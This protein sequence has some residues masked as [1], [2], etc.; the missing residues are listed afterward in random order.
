MAITAEQFMD[1]LKSELPKTEKYIDN[2]T[3]DIY[4]NVSEFVEKSVDS[5]S[6]DVDGLYFDDDV[7]EGVSKT[8]KNQKNL[9]K[10]QKIE[11]QHLFTMPKLTNELEDVS[12]RLKIREKKI[13]DIS[14][15]L[16]GEVVKKKM[17]AGLK[18]LASWTAGLTTSFL[19]VSM[20]PI[21]EVI[22]YS[23]NLST[24]LISTLYFYGLGVLNVFGGIAWGV[25]SAGVK[26]LGFIVKYGIVTPVKWFWNIGTAA[27]SYVWKGVKAI[28]GVGWWVI[29][30]AVEIFAGGA[31]TFGK[32]LTKLFINTISNPLNWIAL[33]FILFG[34]VGLFS[35][36]LDK[37]VPVL[38]NFTDS[39][40]KKAYE[41]WPI[42]KM[43]KDYIWKGVENVFSWVDRNI[44]EK[45][46]NWE[47]IST[48][49][50]YLNEGMS[51]LFGK[52]KVEKTKNIIKS[53]LSWI[54]EKGT[55]FISSVKSIMSSVAGFVSK[56]A[57]KGVRK[58]LYDEMKTSQLFYNILNAIPTMPEWAAAAGGEMIR[59]KL[60][61]ILFQMGR[62]SD[63]SK[64][65][66]EYETEHRLK[67]GSELVGIRASSLD[68]SKK[69]AVEIETQISE[70]FG[71][72]LRSMFPGISEGDIRVSIL[73][74]ITKGKEIQ[75]GT[76]TPLTQHQLEMYK[77]YLITIQKQKYAIENKIVD[78]DN[79]RLSNLEN[80]LKINEE[81]FQ[82]RLY[83]KGSS[84]I[85][86]S[87]VDLDKYMSKFKRES[88]NIDILVENLP[89]VKLKWSESLFDSAGRILGPSISFLYGPDKAS[90][91]GFEEEAKWKQL[92]NS[93]QPSKFADGGVVSQNIVQRLNDDTVKFVRDNLKNVDIDLDAIKKK[94]E[95]KRLKQS[96]INVSPTIGSTESYE[97][98][99][100]KQLS[101]SILTI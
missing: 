67:L 3:K 47:I 11:Y 26:T 42:I 53:T 41:T 23:F 61:D 49:S 4:E 95:Q 75:E 54:D 30:S 89:D 79:A 14:K 85:K 66:S 51:K 62:P 71:T 17:V 45:I 77:E 59:A 64:Q 83:I 52:E 24:K 5:F 46:K 29:K 84:D 35:L 65:L 28:F 20:S 72:T 73:T 38:V 74:G 70:E 80:E 48:I 33:P 40:V 90:N 68:F 44:L 97:L 39:I 100:M 81:N 2:L 86:A 31:L 36:M 16:S 1:K 6:L 91:I 21:K 88:K 82:D 8:V 22:N 76:R 12:I 69:T 94:K 92:S 99:T 58:Y 101:K 78:I 13:N 10:Q 50:G 57:N 43:I 27:L 56:V 25:L 9:I 32:W 18:N 34:S 93:E 19:S 15:S 87:I 55:S 37:V 7:I 63:V 60:E 98:Y 96:I